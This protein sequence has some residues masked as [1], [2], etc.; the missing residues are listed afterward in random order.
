MFQIQTRSTSLIL[1]WQA[2]KEGSLQL[3]IYVLLVNHVQKRPVSKVSYWYLE[4]DAGLQE[5]KLPDVA[6]AEQL[7]MTV[8]KQIKLA[9]KLERFG[10]PKGRTGLS[11]L[12]L[13]RESCR[14][15]SLCW[16]R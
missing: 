14:K 1:N 4:G 3:P 16:P 2:T 12:P 6:E 15:G 10:A 11:I 8:A 9:R 5:Q 13:P 7:I